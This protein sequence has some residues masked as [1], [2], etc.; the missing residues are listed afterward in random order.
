MTVSRDTE[1]EIRR[2]FFAEHWKRG[3]IATQLGIHPDVVTRAIG[4]LG[5]KARAGRPHV[6]VLDAY[7]PFVDETL[8]TYPRLV[9]TRPLVRHV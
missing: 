3:T 6:R 4:P 1:A 9:A 5:P 8:A 7:I 2:L